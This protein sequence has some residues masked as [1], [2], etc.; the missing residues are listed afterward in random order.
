[1]GNIRTTGL[2]K[3]AEAN[4]GN[5]TVAAIDSSVIGHDPDRIK[6]V[7]NACPDR[8]PPSATQYD[9]PASRIQRGRFH[10]NSIMIRKSCTAGR[11]SGGYVKTATQR[12]VAAI[13]RDAAAIQKLNTAAVGGVGVGP[14]HE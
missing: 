1:M 12:Y 7:R 13:G 2:A 5:G 11:K 9:I 4:K 6:I 14:E 10:R 8:T 3:L